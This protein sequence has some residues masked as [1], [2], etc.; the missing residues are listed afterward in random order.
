MLRISA[1]YTSRNYKKNNAKNDFR[2]PNQNLYKTKILFN[3]MAKG[4]QIMP[5]IS[6]I[7]PKKS[8]KRNRCKEQEKVV[9]NSK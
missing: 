8:S 7:E 5:I 1:T 3:L 2:N 4:S 9:L 6:K